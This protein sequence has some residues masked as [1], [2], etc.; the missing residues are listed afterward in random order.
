MEMCFLHRAKNICS[1]CELYLQELNRLSVFF[2]I[3]GYP[4]LFINDTITNVERLKANTKEKCE[5]D[6]LLQL[7]YR[8]LKKILFNFPN[9]LK[10]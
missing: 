7:V 5:K 4:N 6:F 9:G 8:I 3:N 2:Q 10:C 1:A